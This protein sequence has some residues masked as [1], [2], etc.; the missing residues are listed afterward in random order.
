[1]Y[2]SDK[3][4]DE[5]DVIL[6][7]FQSISIFTDESMISRFGYDEMIGEETNKI[8]DSFRAFFMLSL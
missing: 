6:Y 4:L 7:M 2:F 3:P 5:Q 1:M 8:C